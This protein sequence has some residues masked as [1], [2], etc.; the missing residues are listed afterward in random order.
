MANKSAT[1]LN[2]ID[3]LQV[4]TLLKQTDLNTEYFTNITDKVIQSYSAELDYFMEETYKLINQGNL[5]TDTI[6]EAMLRLSNMLYFMGEK[7]ELVGIKE[8]VAK[9]ARQEVYNNAYLENDIE[10]ETDS[11]KKVKPTKDANQAVAEEKSKYENVIHNIYERTY[12]V[13]KFKI[14]AGYELLSSLKKI[15]NRRVQEMSLSM[16]NPKNNFNM[17]EDN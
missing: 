3:T 16:Y 9:A 17:K 5:E 4:D 11:G 8:D 6:E 1:F 10:I 15:I 12:K 13:I 7:L 14:D 2:N